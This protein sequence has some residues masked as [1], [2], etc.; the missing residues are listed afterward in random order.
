MQHASADAPGPAAKVPKARR[1]HGA[2][3]QAL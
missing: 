3:D 1:L 2:G